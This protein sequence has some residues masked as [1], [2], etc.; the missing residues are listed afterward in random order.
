VDNFH[1]TV[2]S[3]VSSSIHCSLSY[4]IGGEER[5]EGTGF[6][7]YSGRLRASESLIT[8]KSEAAFAR[9]LL[10]L[11]EGTLH[12]LKCATFGLLREA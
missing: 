12:S 6:L 2:R 10:G 3:V 1:I 5:I 7:L 4:Q 8:R 11:L 9:S